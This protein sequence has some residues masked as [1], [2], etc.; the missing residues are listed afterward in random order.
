MKKKILLIDVDDTILDFTKGEKKAITLTLEHFGLPT[1]QKTIESY[2]EFNDALWKAYE[3]GEITKPELV[4]KRF[5]LLLEK[6]RAPDRIEPQKMNEVYFEN[7]KIQCEYREGAEEFLDKIKDYYRIV[8][9]TNGTTMIQNS[10]LSL[11]GLIDKVEKVFISEQLSTKKPELE[12]FKIVEN[13]LEDFE[14]S[15]CVLCGDSLTSDIL[16]GLRYG[17]PTVWYNPNGNP[18]RADIKPDYTVTNFESLC[19]LLISFVNG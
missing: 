17:V 11:S 14:K 8:L 7:L 19:D 18:P 3:R 12:F 10:R 2:H 5:S 15:D 4:L 16:G 6:L 13:N 1:D 9:I